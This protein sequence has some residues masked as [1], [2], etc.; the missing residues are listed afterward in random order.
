MKRP[1]SYLLFLIFYS[2]FISSC[3]KDSFITSP[4]ATIATSADSI[5][6]DTVFT[7]TG[8]ITQ[9]FKIN[10][11]NDQKLLLNK[12]KLMGG[13]SSYFKI[14]INGILGPEADNISINA[15]DSIYV[16]VTVNINPNDSTLPFII[17]DSVLINYNGN[18]RFVQLQA[19]GQNAHFIDG[20]RNGNL[21]VGNVTW[22]NDLPYVILGGMQIDTGATLTIQPGC[23]IYSHADAPILVDGTLK[24]NGTVQQRI[25]FTGDRLDAD[26]K[27]LPASWPGIYFRSTS[28]DNVLTQTVIKNAY[29]AVVV[30][31]FATNSNP[32]L[33]MHQCIIDNAYDVGLWCFGTN[34]Q[35]DNS[36]ISNCGRN[37]AID[38]G[39]NYN[40]INC[41]VASFGNLYIP[42][43]NPVLQVDNFDPSTNIPATLNGT[44]TNCIF[45]G[46]FGSVDDEVIVNEKAPT[47]PIIFNNCIYK[48]KNDPSSSF[49][50][51]N[52]CLKNVNPNFDS[53]DVNRRIF[54]FHIIKDTSQAIDN[55]VST[56]PS[57]QKDLDD[58][59][60]TVNIIDIGCYEKQ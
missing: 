7:Q 51:F 16:F 53:I 54:D 50:T 45:Y 46:D 1:L 15:N 43:K 47:S 26:Y 42:H 9:I 38:N 23:R 2:L 39:G 32:K 8:S 36:L 19:Y 21:I 52:S 57:F 44:F 12:V 33:I 28:T 11:L 3:K 48:V 35:A 13:S 59:P 29:Q 14:N 22:T 30:D 27:D 20:I 24:T 49:A 56:V 34:V 40:F 41:T 25:V 5:K 10:N 6:F 58:N 4:N 18:N 17:S 55:G 60:R 37:L 31:S